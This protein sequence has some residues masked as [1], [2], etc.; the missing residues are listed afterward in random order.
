MESAASAYKRMIM[1][2]NFQQK[3]KNLIQEMSEDAKKENQDF[4]AYLNNHYKKL[5]KLYLPQDL[6]IICDLLDKGY[7]MREVTEAYTDLNYFAMDIS[8]DDLVKIYEDNVFSRVNSERQKR[9]GKEYDRAQKAYSTYMETGG[10]GYSEGEKISADYITGAAVISLLVR[11]GFAEATVEDVLES[12]GEHDSAYIKSMMEK[13]G[14]VKQAYLDIKNAGAL[15]DARDEYDAYR[16]YAK[17]YMER[18]GAKLL[19]FEDELEII[20]YMK[21]ENF[22]AELL[23]KAVEKA[24][25]VAIEPGRNAADY[26]NAVMSGDDEHINARSL[27][28]SIKECPDV[29]MDFI[30]NMQRDLNKAGNLRGITD[31]NRPYYDCL[32]IRH[33]LQQHY[34]E[35]DIMKTINKH[36]GIAA[37]L[38]PNYAIWLVDKAKKLLRKE[39]DWLQRN[40]PSIEKCKTY[41]ELT[42]KGIAAATIVMAVLHEH[43]DLNPSLGQRLFA[44]RL[45]KDIAESCLNRYPDFNREALN[46]VFVESPRAIALSGIQSFKE[47]DYAKDVVKEAENRLRSY[48]DQVKEEQSI[49]QEFNKQHGLSYQGVTPQDNA[50]DYHCGRTALQMMKEGYDELEIRNAIMATDLPTGKQPEKYAD[51]IIAKAHKVR[52]RLKNIINYQEEKEPVTAAEFY[53]KRLHDEYNKRHFVRSSMDVAIVKDMLAKGTWKGKDIHEAVGLFSPVAA[54][55]GRDEG[56]FSNY[57]LPNA[58]NRLMD[59]K[60]K[61]NHYHPIPRQQHSDSITEEYLYH[62]KR[63]KQ[64]IDLPYN[65]QMDELIAETMLIQ[66][67]NPVELGECFQENSPVAGEQKSYGLNLV[68]HVRFKKSPIAENEARASITE[69]VLTRSI[70]KVTETTVTEG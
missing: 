56:Y 53:Q 30:E 57:V 23:Q 32:A 42:G 29:Y 14:H 34:P 38:R 15:D 64:A 9:S 4:K 7:S 37:S 52:E 16:S 20:K 43:L 39:Q 65:S 27:H 47:Q 28:E 61:L 68:N 1:E 67:F 54:E 21:D 11:D 17:G 50:S 49:L 45:D 70:T 26:V 2:E 10:K 3:Y 5:E 41:A 63:I 62:Q 44:E 46:S 48:T 12:S 58:K 13:C 69:N 35:K 18:T 55:P 6:K 24:S 19:N 59:E 51:E 22:P 8:N 33:L 36:S 66:G 60:E 40:L 31:E 25:P